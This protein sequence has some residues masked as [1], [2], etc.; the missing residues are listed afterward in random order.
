MAACKKELL[1]SV[2]LAHGSVPG[3]VR[4]VYGVIMTERS[5]GHVEKE[6]ARRMGWRDS[7]R[8]EGQ[9]AWLWTLCRTPAC[10]LLPLAL[11]PHRREPLGGPASLRFHAT[12]PKAA[13]GLEFSFLWPGNT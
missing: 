5:P 3:V 11:S 10:C 7:G 4:M 9:L 2:T 12:N 8:Q 1:G 6:G 13:E